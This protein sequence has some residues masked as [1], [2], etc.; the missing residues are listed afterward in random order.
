ML[1]ERYLVEYHEAFISAI[2]CTFQGPF[3][4]PELKKV[5]I[6]T[7]NF[8]QPQATQELLRSV[9]AHNEYANIEIIVIDNGSII[10]PT[11][12]LSAEF[13]DP[14][15]IRS[16]KNL[17]FAG[18]NNLGIKKVSGDYLFFVNNDTEFTPG[19]VEKLV[20]V[21]DNNPSVGITCPKIMYHA[22]PDIIQYAG[23]TEMNFYTGRNRCVGQYEP[24]HGQYDLPAYPTSYAHGAAMMVRRE[25]I[26]KAGLMPELYFLYYEEM[27]WCESIKSV[28]FEIWVEPGAVIYHKESLSVGLNTP[29]KEYYMTRNRILF[30]RRNAT[31]LQSA[32]FYV[33]FS[34]ILTPKQIFKHIFSG[35]FDL[36]K[37]F[38]KAVWW[39]VSSKESS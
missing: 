36:L 11:Q 29:L 15:Y 31:A 24:D 32:I 21:L 14:V 2:L 7:V 5:S 37:A 17:G 10:D 28:G 1:F 33:Y 22:Q 20:S 16:Q 27:D 34:L 13:P 3:S 8:N 19:L 23:F 9:A 30:I 18:G 38:F 4:K 39:N 35:R 26:E 25:A 12:E 6:I